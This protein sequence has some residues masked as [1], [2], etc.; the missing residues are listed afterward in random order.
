MD[1]LPTGLLYDLSNST[2]PSGTTYNDASGIW[3]LSTETIG[4]GATYILEIA[5]KITPAC[6]ELTNN[7]EIISS[8]K[9]DSDS[10]VN[11]GN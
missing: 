5:A 4:I 8:N 7:A 2:I 11:N 6:G 3:N 10:T 9:L 1:K